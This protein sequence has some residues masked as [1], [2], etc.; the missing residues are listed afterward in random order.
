ME[1]V[2]RVASSGAPMWRVAIPLENSGVTRWYDVGLGF[3]D[4]ADKIK[5][6]IEMLPI[7]SKEWDGSIY[8][9]PLLEK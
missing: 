6:S 2:Q 5:L 1:K 3:G 7:P 8:L 9:F 4:A